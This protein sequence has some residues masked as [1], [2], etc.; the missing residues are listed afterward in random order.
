MKKTETISQSKAKKGIRSTLI[1]IFTNLILALIK[2]ITGAVGNSYALIA[3]AIE[4]LSDVITSIVV[5]SG[6]R[7]AAK[8]P[9]DNHPYGHGKAEPMTAAVVSIALFIAAA[10]IIIQSINEI[11]TPHKAPAAFTLYV[12][13]GVIFI[14]EGLF[15]FVFKV[16]ENIESGAVKSDAW[17]H[18]SDAITSAAVFVGIS[19]ALVGGDGYESAD[20]W[21]ALIAS[22]IIIFNAYRLFQPAVKEL[23]DSSPSPEIENKIRTNALL[24]EGVIAL[25][26]CRI[27]KMGFDYYVDLDIIVD[28]EISVRSGHKIAHKVKDQLT[29]TIPEIANVLVHV[30]PDDENRL[31]RLELN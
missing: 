18:R 16:G 22:F 13:A 11:I 30:E 31:K 3:D 17:H 10:V 14:K 29:K 27:R 9:D 23:M 19:I 25:D 5:Y 26:K 7:I 20:D 15:R 28:G 2:G 12:L 4:S 6:L 24:V 8:P 1:G 21:S